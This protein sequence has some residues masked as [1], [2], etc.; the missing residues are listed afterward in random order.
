MALTTCCIYFYFALLICFLYSLS[1]PRDKKAQ[2]SRILVYG[3]LPV[4]L[5]PTVTPGN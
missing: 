3:D 4:S 2:E 5:A 1:A